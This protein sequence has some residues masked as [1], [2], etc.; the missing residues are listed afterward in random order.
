M[1]DFL[2]KV[3]SSVG[4]CCYKE[5]IATW[6]KGESL[7]APDDE[8]KTKRSDL[9]SRIRLSRLSVDIFRTQQQLRT[10]RL[11]NGRKIDL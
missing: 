7:A 5:A 2:A 3:S 1:V 9:M 11:L 4:R 6:A 8:R 10:R